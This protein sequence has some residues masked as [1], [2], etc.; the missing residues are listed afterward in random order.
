VPRR[1]DLDKP[2]GLVLLPPALVNSVEPPE[3]VTTAPQSP[4][5]VEPTASSSPPAWPAPVASRADAP[6][7][8][9]IVPVSPWLVVQ[10]CVQHGE[11]KNRKNRGRK[12]GG[13]RLVVDKTELYDLCSESHLTV[14]IWILELEVGLS[15]GGRASSRPRLAVAMSR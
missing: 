14:S 13:C 10:V 7:A 15:C 4:A 1:L 2:D 5:E 9:R 11:E 3:R 12:P 6:V 8:S